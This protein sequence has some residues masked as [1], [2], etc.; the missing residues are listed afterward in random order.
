MLLKITLVS[1][2]KKARKLIKKDP[3]YELY[4][5]DDKVTFLYHWCCLSL[6]LFIIVFFVFLDVVRIILLYLF[7]PFILHTCDTHICSCI[8]FK[9]LQEREAEYERFCK[10]R[11]YRCKEEFRN[12]LRE[13]KCITYR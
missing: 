2:W 11:K 9:S 3:R 1:S 10:E 7:L 13:T 8:C 12:L 5:E 4:G 6:V